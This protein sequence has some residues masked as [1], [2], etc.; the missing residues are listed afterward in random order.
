MIT[1]NEIHDQIE[2]AQRVKE[3]EKYEDELDQWA[4]FGYIHGLKYAQGTLKAKYN[5]GDI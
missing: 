5:K 1:E 4:L 3:L 2:I